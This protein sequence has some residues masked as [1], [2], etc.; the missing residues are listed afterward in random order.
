MSIFKK[1]GNGIVNVANGVANVT[2]GSAL[3]LKE[4]A[5]DNRFVN[6]INEIAEYGEVRRV[7]KAK[8]VNEKKLHQLNKKIAKLAKNQ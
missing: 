7:E 2:V 8:L 4:V 1:I 5:V 3:T 6:K